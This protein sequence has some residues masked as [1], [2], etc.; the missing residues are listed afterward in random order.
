MIL[1]IVNRFDFLAL[2]RTYSF[3]SAFADNFY[4]EEFRHT[5]P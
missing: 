4:K 2:N 3:V 5:I 1:Y